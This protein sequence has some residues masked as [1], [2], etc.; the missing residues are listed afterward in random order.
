MAEIKI[1]AKMVVNMRAEKA[2]RV[3]E[4]RGEFLSCYSPRLPNWRVFEG[5]LAGDR[6][7]EGLL[8]GL[9]WGWKQLMRL[10]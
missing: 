9:L 1:P 7:R 4:R 5:R 10:E 2:D 8:M 6:L 3:G